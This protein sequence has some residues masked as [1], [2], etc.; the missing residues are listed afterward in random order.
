VD[1]ETSKLAE[2]FAGF[3]DELVIRRDLL[4]IDA[5][6]LSGVFE[7]IVM[8]DEDRVIEHASDCGVDTCDATGKTLLMHAIQSHWPLIVEK[9]LRLGADVGILDGRGYSPLYYAAVV[10]SVDCVKQLLTAGAEPSQLIGPKRDQKVAD[11]EYQLD[12]RVIALI[13]AHGP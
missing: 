12:S 3:V 5:S 11:V 4:E 2:S 8:G 13:T 6:G 9:L 1:V 10:G 7:D